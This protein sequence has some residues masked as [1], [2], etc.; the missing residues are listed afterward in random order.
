MDKR[1]QLYLELLESSKAENPANVKTHKL[2]TTRIK[3]AL[4]G[5]KL[6][7]LLVATLPSHKYR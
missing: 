3:N 2:Q 1:T 5:G 6:S 7:R 4:R